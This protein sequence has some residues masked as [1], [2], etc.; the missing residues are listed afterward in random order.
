M[1]FNRQQLAS[2]QTLDHTACLAGPGTGKTH[3]LVGKAK[4]ILNVEPTAKICFVT[5]TRDSK[6]EI[7][8]RIKD[9]LGHL[10]SQVVVGTFH[11]LALQ[12]V[13]ASKPRLKVSCAGLKS[14]LLRRVIK[15]IGCEDDSTQIT[16]EIERY[17]NGLINGLSEQTGQCWDM[18]LQLSENEGQLDL[19]SIAKYALDEMIAKRISILDCDYL[20][21]DEFQDVDKLQLGWALEHARSGVMTTVVGDDDQSIYAFRGSLGYKA[22]AAFIRVTK[23]KFVKL[24]TNYRSAKKIVSYANHLIEYNEERLSKSLIAQ[25]PEE[26]EIYLKSYSSKEDEI[27]SLVAVIQ[28]VGGEWGVLSRTKTRLVEVQEEFL[29]HNR[30]TEIKQN[31]NFWE[32]IYAVI[33]FRTMRYVSTGGKVRRFLSGALHAAGKG[34]GDI[35]RIISNPSYSNSL[36]QE[37][38][39]AIS[40]NM[41]GN[42]SYALQIILRVLSSHAMPGVV[43]QQRARNVWNAALMPYYKFTG[44]LKELCDKIERSSSHSHETDEQSVHLHTFHGSKGLEF[45]NVWVLGIN[46]GNVPNSKLIMSLEE[47]RRLLFVAMTRA[48]NTLYLSWT[49]GK[50][51]RSRFIDELPQSSA[52]PLE[53]I[54]A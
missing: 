10:A 16:D 14:L 44:T 31:S 39:A 24:V 37:L 15:E 1:S 41:N 13:K 18:Y 35:R 30:E 49:R 25:S 46:E 28:A 43:D 34:E 51:A 6:L 48:R 53:A 40:A 2:I 19:A 17:Q 23:P 54:L 42:C 38:N 45:D 33:L 7:E 12:Q 5:F 22:F 27:S 4:Y 11:S 29:L 3:M 8:T 26:G 20:F 32:D 9:E 21:V 47:E 50:V 52:Q 36:I